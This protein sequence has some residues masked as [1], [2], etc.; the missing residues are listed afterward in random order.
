MASATVEP[1][2]STDEDTRAPAGSLRRPRERHA[3]ELVRIVLGV[4]VLSVA[5]LPV[6]PDSIGR[7]ETG[8]FDAINGLPDLLYPV[9]WLPMQLGSLSAVPIVIVVALVLKRRRLAVDAAVAGVA[10]WTLAKVVKDAFGRPRP[11]GL[12]EE[13]AFRGGE[14]TGFGFV[15]GH[16]SVAFALATVAVLYLPRR[17]RWRAFALAGVVGIARMFVGAHLPLDVVGGAALGWAIGALWRFAIGAPTGRPHPERLLDRL[18]AIGIDVSPGNLVP[19][20]DGT[21][22]AAVYRLRDVEGHGDLFAKVVSDR[23]QDRDVLHRWWLRGRSLLGSPLDKVE[24]RAFGSPLLQVEHEAMLLLKARSLEV[25]VPEVVHAGALDAE[26][27]VLVTAAVDG[28]RLDR[29]GDVTA[30][31]RDQLR[32]DLRRLHDARVVHGDIAADNLLVDDGR[33]WWTDFGEGRL[34]ARSE[35][36]ANEE[37][38]LRQLLV[39]LAVDSRDGVPG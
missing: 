31:L 4:V 38:A 26:L 19:V 29:H 32:H 17:W 2:T 36:L 10:A 35:D 11:G 12:L 13:V 30:E 5:S 34:Q 22:T 9:L 25:C 28:V 16:T 33:V 20:D 14:P 3:S 37:E 8:V 6:R 24:Q 39:D 1:A 21:T 23:R 18:R 27:A 7:I 15:S